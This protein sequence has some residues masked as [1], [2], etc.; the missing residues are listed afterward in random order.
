MSHCVGL[1]HPAS[2]FCGVFDVISNHAPDGTWYEVSGNG[3]G[4]VVVLCHGVGLDLHMWDQQL[5][6]LISDF[7]VVRYDFIGHGKTPPNKEVVNLAAFTSQLFSL[8][9]HLGLKQ[10]TLVG[11]SMGG[12]IAQRFAADHPEFLTRLVLMNTVYQRGPKE[13]GG[14]EARLRITEEQGL[15][16]IA[17]SA[18]ARWFDDEFVDEHPEVV[19]Q[20]RT[21]LLTNDLAGYLAAYRVFV[22]AEPEI[23]SALKQVR[24]PALVMT[25]GKDTGSTPAMAHRMAEDLADARVVIFDELHHLAPLEK[26]N[27]VNVE[28]LSFLH[29]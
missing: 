5:P 21:R 15:S 26:P 14:V 17:D 3:K 10:I 13:L 6:A 16:P 25:G 22:Y 12:V 7:Q 9:K 29:E 1:G 19:D 11:L 24:C 8:I 28:L 27:Y 20:I 2:E 23:G 18:I 4:P